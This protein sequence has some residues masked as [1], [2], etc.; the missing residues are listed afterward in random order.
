MKRAEA[1]LRAIRME[2]IHQA[3]LPSPS[4]VT[5]ATSSSGAAHKAE[6]PAKVENPET[7]L[8]LSSK[9][10]VAELERKPKEAP[11]FMAEI[12]EGVAHIRTTPLQPPP[13]A[14]IHQ[15]EHTNTPGSGS[16]SGP[17]S[18]TSAGGAGRASPNRK[19]GAMRARR[20][21]SANS[22]HPYN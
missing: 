15:H 6:K 8:P 16:R 7:G 3:S 20:S 9:K 5:A 13:P 21:F 22:S 14:P 19:A 4:S 11:D 18:N 10:D 12:P 2:E 1:E 17:G